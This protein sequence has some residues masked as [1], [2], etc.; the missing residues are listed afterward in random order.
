MKTTPPRKDMRNMTSSDNQQYVTVE[1]F[2]NG[3]ADLKESLKVYIDG[4][5][6]QVE[7]KIDD[8]KAEV[9]VLERNVA[10]NSARIEDLHHSQSL[11]FTILGAVIVFV[12]IVAAIAPIFR[13]I[14]RESRKSSKH[15]QEIRDLREEFAR[16]KMER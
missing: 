6:V 15:E 8:L 4:R 2:N 5:L 3:I 10:V 16:F 12:G 11:G 1:M 14:Y 13:E 9:I 7:K